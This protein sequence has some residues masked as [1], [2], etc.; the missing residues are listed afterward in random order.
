MGGSGHVPLTPLECM[1]NHFKAAF[2]TQDYGIKW[3]R[4]KLRNFCEIDWPDLKVR[5]PDRGTFDPSIAIRVHQ[6]VFHPMK[7]IPIRPPILMS[8]SVYYKDLHLGSRS[9][10]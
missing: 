1:L 9:V 2:M 6:R 8:G 7:D 10:K 3:S 5:W 4:H